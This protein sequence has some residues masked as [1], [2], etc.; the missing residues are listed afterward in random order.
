MG[1]IRLAAIVMALLASLGWP[2]A[3]WSCELRVGWEPYA[4]YTFNDEQGEPAG[5]D[6]DLLH[7]VAHQVGCRLIFE[8]LPWARVI[9]E[10]ESGMLDVTSSASRNAERDGFAHFSVP[11]REAEVAIFVK[12]GQ[13]Q[14]HPLESLAAIKKTEFR[15]GAIAGY[16]YT[17]EFGELMKDPDFAARI[18]VSVDYPT[19]LRKLVHGRIDGYIVDDVGVLVAEARALGVEDQIERHPLRFPGEPLHLMFS[20][21]SVAPDIVQATNR[22]IQAMRADGRMAQIMKKYLP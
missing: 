12:R 13:T 4:V 5:A 18:D 10:I 11:Y 7:E 21:K 22:I 17:D 16:H 19:N 14:S 3:A 1:V 6:I 2:A 8:E 9:L 20:R 15:L